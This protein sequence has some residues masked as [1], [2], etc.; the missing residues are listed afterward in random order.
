MNW[1][2]VDWINI[3]SS[4]KYSNLM[5]KVTVDLI[6]D[7][8]IA[9]LRIKFKKEKNEW[10]RRNRDDRRGARAR[11]IRSNA[12]VCFLLIRQNSLVVVAIVNTPFIP[13][14]F[15][16]QIQST[17]TTFLDSKVS[18]YFNRKLMN[19]KIN[20]KHFTILNNNHVV[21]DLIVTHTHPNDMIIC[22]IS[23]I[24]GEESSFYVGNEEEKWKNVEFVIL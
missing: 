18:V 5:E 20:I 4:R 12:A 2:H 1:R 24:N 6:T 3:K 22:W 15:C 10:Q 8:V 13:S 23:L 11:H 9:R 17:A 21:H 14:S 19:A 16:L 7:H